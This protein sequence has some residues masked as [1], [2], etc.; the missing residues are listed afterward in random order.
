LQADIDSI[1]AGGR[2]A[3]PEGID[4]DRLILETTGSVAPAVNWYAIHLGEARRDGI[5]IIVG[6]A[7]SPAID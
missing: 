1:E 5:P 4:A 2:P 3:S 7:S 6:H